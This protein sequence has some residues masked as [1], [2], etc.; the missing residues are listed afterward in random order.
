MKRTTT[1]GR[2]EVRLIRWMAGVAVA[3]V[4][5]ALAA[6]YGRAALGFLLGAATAILA[7]SWLHQSVAALLD[8]GRTR[9]PKRMVLKVAIRYPLA[10]GLMYLFYRTG[11]APL[12]A[13]IG[14]LFVPAAGAVIECVFQVGEHFLAPTTAAHTELAGG[15]DGEPLSPFHL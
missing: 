14:G 13:V 3:G 11:W 8:L 7:Y 15:D 9:V 5:I 2:A 1:P 10:F 6:G 4:L 12:P